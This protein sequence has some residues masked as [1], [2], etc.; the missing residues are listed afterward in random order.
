MAHNCMPTET[1]SNLRS[2]TS[3]NV[4]NFP[5]AF[6][7]S[8]KSSSLKNTMGIFE[9]RF[10]LA[11][12][13]CTTHFCNVEWRNSAHDGFAQWPHWCSETSP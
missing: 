3:Q 11:C 5:S 6:S 1:S 13:E 2:E 8:V 9:I 7:I 4:H 12:F 10:L